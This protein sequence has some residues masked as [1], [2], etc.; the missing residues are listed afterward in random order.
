MELVPIDIDDTKNAT[1]MANDDCREILAMYPPFYVRVGFNPPWIGYFM[2]RDGEF[3][4]CGGFKGKPRDRKVEISYHTFRR[5]E[6]EGI[7]TA[8]CRLLVSISLQADP[9]TRVTAR[10]LPQNSASTSILK[11]NGFCFNGIVHDEEDG[12]VWEW[13]YP[14]KTAAV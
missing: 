9:N 8:I 13:E 10:T 12:D 5:F 14:Y 6:G 7:G 1:L 3:V 11:K 4:G 2:K